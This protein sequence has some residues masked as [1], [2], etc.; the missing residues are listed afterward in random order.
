MPPCQQ[1]SRKRGW[2]CGWGWGRKRGRGALKMGLFNARL[3]DVK[4]RG[5]GLRQG[6]TSA[7]ARVVSPKLKKNKKN[8]SP[9]PS[10][11]SQ[12]SVR[13]Q[14]RV[15]LFFISFEPGFRSSGPP[16]R[17][18]FVKNSPSA[19]VIDAAALWR[20]LGQAG[21]LQ[22]R[23]PLCFPLSPT[24]PSP[25]P[26]RGSRKSPSPVWMCSSFSC[27]EKTEPLRSSG[28]LKPNPGGE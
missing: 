2:G 13:F 18:G 20:Q 10:L 6:A 1:V 5:F 8:L 17:E 26:P 25:T 15:F 28:V 22:P 9:P 3:A 4:P 11:L 7:G 24:P 21:S 23:L 14:A 27:W 12:P 16:R 19:V